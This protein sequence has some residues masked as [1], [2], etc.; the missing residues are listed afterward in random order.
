M[1]ILIIGVLFVALMVFVSTKIKKSAARAF[2]R[3]EIETADFRLSKPDNLMHPLREKSE[4]AFEA[5]SKDFGDGDARSIWRA[6][7]L[8]RTIPGSDSAAVRAEIREEAD[9]VVADG[10]AGEDSG[11]YL[12]ETLRTPEDEHLRH[13]FWKIVEDRKNDRIYQLRVSVLEAHLE[14]YAEKARE[15]IESFRLK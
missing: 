10:K 9:R 4:Y 15:M 7:A 5:Y 1:E 6:H 2:E 11:T 14:Q 8:L 12:L 3:E 13:E